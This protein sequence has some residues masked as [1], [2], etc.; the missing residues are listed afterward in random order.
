MIIAF[1]PSRT[2]LKNLMFCPM[3]VLPPPKEEKMHTYYLYAAPF[4]LLAPCHQTKSGTV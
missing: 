4:L 1:G 3:A 2:G